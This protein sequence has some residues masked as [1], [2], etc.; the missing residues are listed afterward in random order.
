MLD[1]QKVI[2]NLEIYQKI[3]RGTASGRGVSWWSLTTSCGKRRALTDQL[4]Q[5]AEAAET[6]VQEKK[7]GTYFHGLKDFWLKGSLPDGL[8]IDLGPVQEQ[9]WAE[10]LRL[11]NF[12]RDHFPREYWG[13]YVGSEV[14]LPVNDDHK[15]KIA[16]F[17]GHDEITGAVDA[18]FMLSAPDVA[19][20]EALRG[21]RLNGPGLYFVDWKTTAARKTPQAAE[22]YYTESM[23]ALTYPVLWNLAGG[24]ECKGMIF[25]VL[26][27]HEELRVADVSPRKLASVQTFFA[28]YRPENMLI[29]KNGIDIAKE[30][31]DAARADPFGCYINGKC[32]FIQSGHC[33]RF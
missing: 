8:A 17:F 21:I 3:Q 27:K 25:D 28:P 30:R 16:S 18:I 13:E 15:A 32:P 29:V 6:N 19:R 11:F 26:V 24:E 22:Q 14:K 23:Q 12:H 31:R 10:A 33:G 9:E 20:L 1:N 7:L 5:I 4:V 2:D